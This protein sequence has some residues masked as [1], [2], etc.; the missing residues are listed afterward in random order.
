VRRAGRSRGFGVSGLRD[1]LRRARVGLARSSLRRSVASARREIERRFRRLGGCRAAQRQLA[2]SSPAYAMAICLLRVP[3]GIDPGPRC[4]HRPGAIAL[5][6]GVLA[7]PSIEARI[8]WP[9][10]E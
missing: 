2:L 9:P 7:D 5:A 3:R 4:S 8:A 10:G 6:T 1:R